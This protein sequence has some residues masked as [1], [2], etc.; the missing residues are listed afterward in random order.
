MLVPSETPTGLFGYGRFYGVGSTPAE[1]TQEALGLIGRYDWGVC[2]PIGSHCRW[3]CTVHQ[4]Q[5]GA[6]L[7]ISQSGTGAMTPLLEQS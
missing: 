7:A 2:F 4:F 3:G 5:Y 1:S 6:R